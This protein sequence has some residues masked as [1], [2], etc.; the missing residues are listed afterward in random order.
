MRNMVILVIFLVTSIIVTGF[1]GCKE[2]VS[3]QHLTMRWGIPEEVQGFEGL[4][5]QP[6]GAEV[7]LVNEDTLKVVWQLEESYILPISSTSEKELEGIRYKG[8]GVPTHLELE[9]LDPWERQWYDLGEI[10]EDM[11]KAHIREENGQLSIDFGPPEGAAFEKG[12]TRVIWF[13]ITPTELEEFEFA[14]YGYLREEG[15]SSVNRVSTILT[16]QAE[17]KE[18]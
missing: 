4:Q 18:K 17:V 13:R 9:W 7:E 10:P 14:I 8:S 11:I 3:P 12:M 5:K 6:E 16:L 2:E 15:E 1:A